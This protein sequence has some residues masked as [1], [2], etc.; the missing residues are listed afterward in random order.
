MLIQLTHSSA[1]MGNISK[2]LMSV[3]PCYKHA[4]NIYHESEMMTVANTFFVL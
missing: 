1:S 2:R 3:Y 4:Q